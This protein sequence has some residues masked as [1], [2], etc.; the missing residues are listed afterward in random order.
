[1][2]LKEMIYH[3][4]SCRNFTGKPVDA[5]FIQKLVSVK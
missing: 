4:K 3:R 5:E 2:T 1:M